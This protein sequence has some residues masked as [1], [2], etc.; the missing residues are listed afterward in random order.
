MG[1][2]RTYLQVHWLS[3]VVAGALLGIGISLLVFGA[4]QRTQPTPAIDPTRAD[5][6][7]RDTR[8]SDA[9]ASDGPRA[10]G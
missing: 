5:A 7:E 6:P 2:S 8:R 3:D 10:E 4:A 9:E 1:W